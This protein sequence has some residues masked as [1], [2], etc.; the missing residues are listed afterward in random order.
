MSLLAPTSSVTIVINTVFARL[1]LGEQM[2][3]AAAIGSC[4]I[5]AGAVTCCI[6]GS[7]ESHTRSVDELKDLFTRDGYVLYQY[8]NAPLVV[9]SFLLSTVIIPWYFSDVDEQLEA[10]RSE[11]KAG[12]DTNIVDQM[13]TTEANVDKIMANVDNGAVTE[14]EVVIAMTRESSTT[15]LTNS[16]QLAENSEPAAEK[17]AAQIE[18][19]E[20]KARAAEI[21][22]LTM[23]QYQRRR[24]KSWWVYGLWTVAYS[25][26]T[27]GIGT[28]TNTFMKCTVEMVGL[29]LD[30]DNQSSDPWF[31]FFLCGV[32]V[33]A[34]AQF[35]S[36]VYMMCTFPAILII[37][38]YQCI[39]IISLIVG[40]SVYFQVHTH[41]LILS[42]FL[43]I[44]RP[45]SLQEVDS[46]S[47]LQICM[48]LLG[49]CVCFAGIFIMTA[50]DISSQEADK[51]EACE[52]QANT[53][54]AAEID[55]PPK[56]S[57]GSPTLGSIPDQ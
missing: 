47:T 55:P 8:V 29:S 42:T 44:S 40:G 19:E 30:G 49:V 45:S 23:E 46:M 20:A 43:L 41:H 34:I 54:A 35:T 24:E 12:L 5:I 52:K 38:I 13:E 51:E 33:C 9:L 32:A 37:P 56:R 4:V 18:E 25:N 7:K 17:S 11:K 36:C 14:G 31:W 21:A 48:F 15:N 3:K 39:F 27:C 53:P 6:F 57:P 26:V 1:V 22:A 28:F 50:V 16:S 2:T 10:E